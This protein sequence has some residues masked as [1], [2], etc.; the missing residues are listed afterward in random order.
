MRTGMVEIGPSSASGVRGVTGSRDFWLALRRMWFVLGRGAL[1]SVPAAAV[2]ALLLGGSAIRPRGGVEIPL[3]QALPAF[4][5]LLLGFVSGT[6]S[7]RLAP[8][9]S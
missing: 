9:D 4:P 3:R 7:T 8:I 5:G 2:V 1:L 6:S